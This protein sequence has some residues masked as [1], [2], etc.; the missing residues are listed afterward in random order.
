M[1]PSSTLRLAIF[2]AV[3][4][5]WSMA[6][7]EDVAKDV[8]EGISSALSGQSVYEAS[9]KSCHRGGI[10]GWFSG[11]PETG[12]KEEWVPLI[13]KGVP[14]LIESSLNGFGDMK[15]K[16]GCETCSDKDVIAAVEYMVAQ[17]R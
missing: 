14:A 9:C 3:L 6:L 11:A 10:G 4:P 2:F 1:S 13:K 8:E 12:D 17:S 16:G 15:A 7:A 5:A